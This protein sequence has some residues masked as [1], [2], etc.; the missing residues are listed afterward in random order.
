MST[1][2]VFKHMPYSAA[3]LHELAWNVE[4]YPKFINFISGLRILKSDDLYMR[5]EVRVKYKFL[6]ESF[7]TDVRRDEGKNAISV[8]L[9]RGPL[10]SLE[11][12]WQFHSLSDGST[13]VE[14]WVSFAFSL[15]VLGSLFRS[16]QQ[17]AEQLILQSFE[18][19]AGQRC[20]KIPCTMD[21]GEIAKEI[22]RLQT[23]SKHS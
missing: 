4:D 17:R 13:V 18:R 20:T 9:T 14:F 6:N 16:K 1:R 10:R 21:E 3:D 8:N 19:R 2:H 15:P 11:N 12:H 5:A 22:K 23:I 7:V